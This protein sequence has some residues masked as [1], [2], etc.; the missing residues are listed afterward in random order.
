MS[1][2]HYFACANSAKGYI[3]LFHSNLAPLDKVYILKGGPGKGMSELMRKIAKTLEEHNE[4]VEYI[5]NPSDPDA[6]DGV[7]F[8]KLNVGIVDGTAPHVIEPKVPGAIEE[9]VNLG[10]S[11]NTEA[12]AGYKDH[13]LELMVRMQQ[14]HEKAYTE[15]KE[16]LKV[17]DEWEKVYIQNMDL[18]RADELTTEVT[19][20]LLP[21]TQFKK[22]SLVKHRF[23][24]GSTPKGPMDFVENITSDITTRYFIKGRPGSGKSTMMKKILRTAE[25][26][27]LDTEVYHC[28]FDP[29]SLDML[30]FPEL[31]LCIFDSTAPHE[32]YPSR[33]G[34]KVIDMYT[35][36]I[37]QGTDEQYKKELAEI[38]IR[39]KSHIKAGTSHLADA[40]THLEELN[41][42]YDKATNFSVVDR[43][44]KELYQK[45]ISN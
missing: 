29:E 15:F 23:F 31:S 19:K 27:G 5:H 32:Y 41:H 12:L 34:D 35:E 2:K 24:G 4:I 40:K 7:I 9:Y 36:I 3:N 1:T 43:I 22:Q 25:A 14:Y 37:K 6:L 8:P 11:W 16:G 33:E 10:V 42:I 39:Y 20:S 28:G 38:Q 13:I 17:H 45:I 21:T 26:Q 44:G 30:L 18:S